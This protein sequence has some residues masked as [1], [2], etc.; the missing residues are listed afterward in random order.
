MKTWNFLLLN[1]FNTEYELFD[2]YIKLLITLLKCYKKIRWHINDFWEEYGPERET[3][4]VKIYERHKYK[5]S[6]WGRSDKNG[7]RKQPTM[8]E[9]SPLTVTA[10]HMKLHIILK[11]NLL[12]DYKASRQTKTNTNK[13]LTVATINIT[14][15]QDMIPCNVVLQIGT[16]F[17]QNVRRLS[18]K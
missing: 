10:N 18:V 5:M 2:N 13:I 8:V 6:S 3:N 12:R 1:F 17:R 9:I 14:I 4:S 11:A 15:T 7:D 16:M